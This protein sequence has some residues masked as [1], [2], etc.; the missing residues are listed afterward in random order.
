MDA[1]PFIN[2]F[3][4]KTKVTFIHAVTGKIIGISKMKSEELPISFIK[5]TRIEF[6]G[7]EWRVMR[8][9]PAHAKEFT[10]DNKLALYVQENYAIDPNKIGFDIATVCQDT[11]IIVTAPLFDSF[12]LDISKDDWRQLELFPVSAFH[13]IQK[14][15]LEVESVLF[16]DDNTNTLAGYKTIHV[17][18]QLL[19]QPLGIPADEFCNQ[20]NI[21]EKGSPRFDRKGFIEN[22]FAFRSPGY[23]YYGIIKDNII[24]ELSLQAFESVDEELY[25][26]A[27]AYDIMLVDWCNG[28]IIMI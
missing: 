28:K 3:N 1:R 19:E 15:M 6:E 22:G 12:S 26:L 14:E 11:P 17:R 27:S 23:T 20:V 2:M 4:G 8:A 13:L 5:P 9:E 16:P 10:I 21:L 7:T 18:K 24:K 25:Q